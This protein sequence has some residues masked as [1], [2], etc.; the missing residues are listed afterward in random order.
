MNTLL[1]IADGEG[2]T[3]LVDDLSRRKRKSSDIIPS[4]RVRAVT[5]THD[6]DNQREIF[7]GDNA[8]TDEMEEDACV[9]AVAPA[10]SRSQRELDVTV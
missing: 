5:R 10:S 3:S 6:D 2:S 1:S 9:H 4:P 8:S 7:L